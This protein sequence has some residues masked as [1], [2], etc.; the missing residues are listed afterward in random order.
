MIE[1]LS[2]GGL[3][4]FTSHQEVGIPNMQVLEL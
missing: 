1:H 2:A 4:V 3:I